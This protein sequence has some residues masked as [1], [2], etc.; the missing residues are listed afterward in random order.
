MANSDISGQ[1]TDGSGNPVGNAEVYL[2]REDLAGAGGVVASTTADSSGNFS[3]T[4]HPDGSGSSES[5]HVAA[6]D[7]NANVQLQSAYGVTASPPTSVNSQF[8]VSITGTSPSPVSPGETLT[9]DASLT[10]SG[11]D[12]DTQTITLDVDNGV[13][14]VDNSLD[15]AQGGASDT[16]TL[17]W[18]VPSGQT[19]QDYTATVASAD[20]TATQT[21]TVRSSAVIDDFEDGDLAEYAITSGA[22]IESGTVFEG[23]HSVSV[24]ATSLGGVQLQANQGGSLPAYFAQGH[25]VTY[26]IYLKGSSADDRIMWGTTGLDYNNTGFEVTWRP[27]NDLVE[28]TVDGSA[29]DSANVT[30]PSGQ[31][32]KGEIEWAS[33]D[34]ITANFYWNGVNNLQASLQMTSTAYSGA[35]FGVGTRKDGL[36]LDKITLE[37]LL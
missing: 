22:S 33:D 31:W 9:V 28:L 2:W 19:E 6:K 7:P 15:A 16:T 32:L 14:Q 12:S 21:V 4:A 23:N 20:D 10:N 35:S 37:G 3:F 11:T 27:L 34:T 5:W 26:Y 13:G 17:S 30:P 25:R 36:F 24:A 1:I 29:Q 8:N 18:A